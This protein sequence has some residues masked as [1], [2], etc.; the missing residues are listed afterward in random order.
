M[1]ENSLEKGI[2]SINK[3]IG[4][5][6]TPSKTTFLHY[7]NKEIYEAGLRQDNFIIK[8]R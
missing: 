3:D 8:S 7:N 4:I 1:L 5:L 6:P 2:N